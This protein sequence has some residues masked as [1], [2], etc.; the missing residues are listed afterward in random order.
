MC[1]STER[2]YRKGAL[3][4]KTLLEFVFVR[5]TCDV[6]EKI[7][8]KYRSKNKES[9]VLFCVSSSPKRSKKEVFWCLSPL[10]GKHFV[11]WKLNSGAFNKSFSRGVPTV[12][13]VRQATSFP[14]RTKNTHTLHTYSQSESTFSLTISSSRERESERERE[15]CDARARAERE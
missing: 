10:V 8:K 11:I 7:R 5:V 6:T 13:V 3:S 14:Q 9:E 4:G 1:E 2:E 15:I 12:K